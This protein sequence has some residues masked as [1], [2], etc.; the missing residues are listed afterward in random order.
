MGRAVKNSLEIII[1]QVRLEGGFERGGRIRVAEC[2][3]Q[4]VPDRKEPKQNRPIEVFLLTSL[5]KPAPAR[6]RVPRPL[7]I[8]HGAMI[9]CSVGNPFKLSFLFQNYGSWIYCTCL[10]LNALLLTMNDAFK[11]SRV[12]SSQVKSSTS[13]FHSKKNAGAAHE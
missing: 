12:K 7:L 9:R 10:W 13:L 5:A 8:S 11:L 1:K 2:L 6:T 3:G 4:I